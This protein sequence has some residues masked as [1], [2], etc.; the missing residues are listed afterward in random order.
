MLVC[1]DTIYDNGSFLHSLQHF[2]LHCDTKWCKLSHCPNI[3]GPSDVTG[4]DCVF[5]HCSVSLWCSNMIICPQV[6]CP[7]H[8]RVLQPI[9]ST[10]LYACGSYAY[11]PHD[12]Y[13]VC[14]HRHWHRVKFTVKHTVSHSSASVCFLQDTEN[15]HMVQHG[16][17]KG[18]CPFN[19]FE[20]NTAISTG[21]SAAVVVTLMTRLGNKHKLN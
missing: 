8:V 16:P 14:P 21:Q 13:I 12:A 19:P 11:S 5:D 1:P 17:A 9:N 4:S 20:R 6:D 15:F 3:Y 18:R 7:N 10:H 2:F